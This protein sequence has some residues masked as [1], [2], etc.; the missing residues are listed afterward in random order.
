MRIKDLP[1]RKVLVEERLPIQHEVYLG[2]IV[3]RAAR[4]YTILASSEGGI[5]IEEVAAKTPRR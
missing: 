3:D 2:V 1:I 4:C 5:N